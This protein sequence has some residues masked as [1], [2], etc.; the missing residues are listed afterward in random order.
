[1]KF[2]LAVLPL[3]AQC[4]I[5]LAS[6]EVPSP[7]RTVAELKRT[8]EAPQSLAN[9]LDDALVWL[10]VRVANPCRRCDGCGMCQGGG[11]SSG[12]GPWPTP[13]PSPRPPRSLNEA[14]VW[15]G[16]R[17]P[18]RREPAE[19]QP[20]PVPSARQP[21]GLS[22]QALAWLGVRSPVEVP[23]QPKE[24]PRTR[25]TMLSW[26]G[27]GSP[28][29]ERAVAGTPWPTPQPSPRPP[30]SLNEALVWFG[31]RSPS[32]DK[33]TREQPPAPEPISVPK[34]RAFA[35]MA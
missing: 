12:G 5:S 18:E 27:M 19:P 3:L 23:A 6:E 2:H 25:N 33:E 1:M 32:T 16:L 22:N 29:V 20:V 28:T 10:G 34:K 31:L 30:R 15:V 8:A 14:L 7:T 35:F 17:S 9:S 11:S 24:Q 13:Q 4:A 26:L 21:R